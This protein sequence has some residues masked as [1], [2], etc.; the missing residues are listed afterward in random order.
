MSY[1]AT[2]NGRI[3]KP[4]C[5]RCTSVPAAP[6]AHDSGPRPTLDALAPLPQEQKKPP[7]P[8]KPPE[9]KRGSV[10]SQSP[11]SGSFLSRR[12]RA[13][14][15]QSGA[16]ESEQVSEMAAKAGDVVG[17]AV[18]SGLSKVTETVG[19]GRLVSESEA[20]A[21]PA[22][23]VLT[24]T[25]QMPVAASGRRGPREPLPA[26]AVPVLVYDLDIKPSM[27]SSSGGEAAA[28]PAPAV[29]DAAVPTSNGGPETDTFTP[30]DTDVVPPIGIRPQLPRELP[31]HVRTE[32]LTRIE[33]LVAA[34]GTVEM[35]KLVSSPRTVHDSMWLSAIKAWQFQP[36]MKDG[37]PVRYLKTVWIAPHSCILSTSFGCSAHG[38]TLAA[39]L[40]VVAAVNRAPG[41]RR[42]RGS[43]QRN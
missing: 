39:C 20:N 19:L 36:A 23:P 35:V 3:A 25:L 7:K 32:Q 10:A 33:L 2:T 34:D 12:T 9:V 15:P 28:I 4:R 11:R 5:R 37:R 6:P 41:S 8:P 27:V 1:L 30:A 22:A 18:V 16:A 42:P 13:A 21:T 38:A 24:P 31:R 17:S 43:T 14:C 26:Q 40:A 29:T